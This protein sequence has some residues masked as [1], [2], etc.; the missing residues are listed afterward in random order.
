MEYYF[1]TET[2]L[3][4]I[5]IC[6]E[7]S[8]LTEIFWTGR[9]PKGICR[10]TELIAQAEEEIQE[11]FARKRTRFTL[12]YRIGG[13]DFQHDVWEALT[14]I[15]YGTTV[16]YQELAVLS[17]HAQACRAVGTACRDNPL[18]LILP[19]HRVVHKNGHFGNYR[20]GSEKKRFLIHLEQNSPSLFPA[21]VINL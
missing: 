9:S 19:C 3:G 10:K 15:P 12:P 20:G 8:F 13:S 14:R 6:A 16:S 17:G 11:Y 2:P 7:D 1:Q 5:T 21:S 18:A 4:P